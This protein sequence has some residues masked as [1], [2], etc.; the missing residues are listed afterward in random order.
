MKAHRCG[1]R[2]LRVAQAMQPGAQQRRRLHLG[3]KHPPRRA[4]EGLHPQPRRPL[5]HRIR[6]EFAQPTGHRIGRARIAI[7]LPKAP[8]ERIEVF[9]M[10]QVQPPAPG[11]QELAPGRGHGVKDIHRHPGA[12][13]HIRRHQAGG[14]GAENGDVGHFDRWGRGHGHGSLK[15]GDCAAP[16]GRRLRPT[17]DGHGIKPLPRL[18]TPMS[19]ALCTG[20]PT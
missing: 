12:R 13:Q 19:L 8:D 14:T 9:R 1:A 6:P 16:A 15:A 2:R 10:R 20:A 18:F 11:Q 4:H 17:P 3:R 5:A 7:A